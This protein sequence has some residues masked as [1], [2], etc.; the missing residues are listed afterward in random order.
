MRNVCMHYIVKFNN[1]VSKSKKYVFKSIFYD[2]F[3]ICV[4]FNALDVELM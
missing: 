2:N 1:N 4:C 3:E